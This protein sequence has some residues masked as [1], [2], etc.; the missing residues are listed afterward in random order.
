MKKLFLLLALPAA[1]ISC[2]NSDDDSCNKLN[3]INASGIITQ[4]RAPINSDG[5]NLP[6][7]TQSVYFV[8]THDSATADWTTVTG[9][10]TVSVGNAGG[11]LSGTMS[12]DGT[13]TL[14]PSQFYHENSRLNS[15]LT[16]YYPASNATY[17]SVTN[18]GKLQWTI[19][20]KTDIMY[21]GIAS[22]NKTGSATP[23]AFTFNHQLSWLSFQI[24]AAAG[25]G[26]EIAAIWGNCNLDQHSQPGHHAYTQSSGHSGILRNRYDQYFFGLR[27]RSGSFGDTC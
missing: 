6:L 17:P 5:S 2:S 4:T 25:T 23:M 11:V 13:I 7:T 26:S 27:L 14:S 18:P 1:I 10:Q 3:Q 8:R 24:Q 15:Y 12:T 9:N 20:G 21:T 19:D 16:G 22:G